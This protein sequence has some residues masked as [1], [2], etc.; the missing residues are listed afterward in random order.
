MHKVKYEGKKRIYFVIMANVFNTDRD[1]HQRFDL[2]GSTKGRLVPEDQVYPGVALKD[3]NFL[4][5]ESNK[6]QVPQEI[7]NT[8]L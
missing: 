3:L 5:T 8:L 7:C 1:I 6:I 4:Q 2:K